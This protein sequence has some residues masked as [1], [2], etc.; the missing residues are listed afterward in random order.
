LGS[1]PGYDHRRRPS[2]G[3][4]ERAYEPR[5]VRPPMFPLYERACHLGYPQE[6]WA[7]NQRRQLVWLFWQLLH[8]PFVYN[9]WRQQLCGQLP[10]QF[11][12]QLQL[13]QQSATRRQPSLQVDVLTGSHQ[14]PQPHVPAGH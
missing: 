9:W 14:L 2:E 12:A 8:E 3:D 5:Q 10:L 1:G 13:P 11:P 7:Q 4:D 6:P